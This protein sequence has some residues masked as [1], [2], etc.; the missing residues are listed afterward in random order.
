M[1]AQFNNNRS[2]WE[3]TALYWAQ[4]YAKAPGT[5]NPQYTEAFNK[6]NAMGFERQKALASLS[7]HN[8]DTEAALQ[9]LFN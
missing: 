4:L 6:L 3:A 5:P 9:Y 2:V 7:Q 1:A 8:W